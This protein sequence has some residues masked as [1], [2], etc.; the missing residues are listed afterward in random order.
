M[1]V[2]QTTLQLVVTCFRN[3]YFYRISGILWGRF[4][5]FGR[6]PLLALPSAGAAMPASRV[7]LIASMPQAPAPATK[8]PSNNTWMIEEPS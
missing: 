2:V 1:K 6:T 3:G 4:I 8:L 5:I 7:I